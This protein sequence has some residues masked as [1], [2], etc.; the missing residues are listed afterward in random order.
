RSRTVRRSYR[1]TTYQSFSLRLRGTSSIVIGWTGAAKVFFFSSCSS[2]FLDFFFAF[3]SLASPRPVGILGPSRPDGSIPDC[4]EHSACRSYA[5][6]R[7]SPEALVT[8]RHH[9]F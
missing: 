7:A 1:L 5:L 6:A 8:A 9:P 4:S 3:L 2:C